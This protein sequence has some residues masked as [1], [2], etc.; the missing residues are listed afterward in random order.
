MVLNLHHHV[1][2]IVSRSSCSR[3]EITLNTDCYSI[4]AHLAYDIL[5]VFFLLVP[6]LRMRRGKLRLLDQTDDRVESI[7]RSQC[8]L[9]GI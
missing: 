8:A 3:G 1:R 2:L 7:V 6:G 4:R 9:Q 5:H